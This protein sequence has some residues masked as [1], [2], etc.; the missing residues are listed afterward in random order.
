MARLGQWSLLA[1]VTSVSVCFEKFI[2][3]KQIIL[4]TYCQRRKMLQSTAIWSDKASCPH[5]ASPIN[6]LARRGTAAVLWIR[7]NLVQAGSDGSQNALILS[8]SWMLH[9]LVLWQRFSQRTEMYNSSL[10]GP[11]S[12]VLAVCTL[13]KSALTPCYIVSVWPKVAHYLLG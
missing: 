3:G 1:P 10:M 6:L 2:R 5:A 11:D 12:L 8:V 7:T 9:T 4:W 13:V